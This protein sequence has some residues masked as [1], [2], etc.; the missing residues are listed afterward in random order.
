MSEEET[1][2]TNEEVATPKTSEDAQVSQPAKAKSQESANDS[3][4]YNFSRLRDEKEKLEKELREYRE[5]EAQKYKEKDELEELDEDDILTVSQAKKLAMKQA[6][7]Y[8]KQAQAEQEKKRLP[9]VTK[10][11]YKD[12]EQVL[13]KENIEKFEKLEPELATAC[14][15]ANNP[16]E[17]AYKM[18]KMTIISKEEPKEAH[19]KIQSSSTVGKRASLSQANQFGKLSREQLYKEM[20]AAAK[21]R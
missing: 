19:S 12:F 1:S 5:R 20:L 8:F 13:S 10:A 21:R 18:I 4:E 16:W 2:V 7:E 6:Q 11:K 15:K 14:S 9:E 3:K 17:A